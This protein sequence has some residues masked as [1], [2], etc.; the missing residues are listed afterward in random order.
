[1]RKFRRYLI[2]LL[3][4]VAALA[5][6]YFFW[7]RDSSLV[8]VEKV[9]VTGAESEPAV[10]AALAAAA[11][12]MTTLNVDEAALYAAVSDM[13]SVRSLGV[14]TDFPNGLSIEVDTRR[15]VAYLDSEGGMLLAGDGVILETGVD[16]PEG[17]PLIESTEPLTNGKAEGGTAA[18]AAIL[19]QAPEPLLAEVTTA[20]IEDGAGP[21]ALIGPGIELRFGDTSRA[22]LKWNAVASVLADPGLDSAEYIDLAV[23]DRPVVG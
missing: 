22:E 19:Q 12:E 16:R 20:S 8:A 3:L 4:L 17:L 6:G 9:T 18:L 5:A 23:P 15:P 14:S 2:L 10:E 7:L 11:T 13:P 21:V 1:M